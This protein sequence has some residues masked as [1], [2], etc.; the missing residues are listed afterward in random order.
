MA[1][2]FLTA[3]IS[4]LQATLKEGQALLISRRSDIFYFSSF[5]A[6]VPEERSAFLLIT[7]KEAHLLLQNFLP[8]PANF[9]GLI[10][11]GFTSPMRLAE[12]VTELVKQNKLNSL[13]VDY[14]DLRV[15]ELQALQKNS[16]LAIRDLDRQ[17]VWQLR[18]QKDES[19]IAKIKKARS[20][21]KQVLL[22]TLAE[23][24]TGQSELEVARSIEKKIRAHTGCDL[25]FP[26]IVAFN[27][28]SALP[29]HQPGSKRL[30]HGSVVLIDVGATY[31][32]YCADMTRTIFW[33]QNGKIDT[34]KIKQ[35]T[36]QFKKIERLVKA[37]YKKAEQLLVN[38]VQLTAAELDLA[39]RDFLTKA[40]Y[41]SQFIHTTGHG[42]GLDIHEPPSLY[43]NNPQ[44]LLPGMV[45]TIEPGIYLPGKFGVR[46]E[47]TVVVK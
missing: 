12:Y 20:I 44:T 46:W 31:Q 38:N 37:A 17:V 25:A 2:R 21:T 6:N 34:P 22:H 9:P 39:C 33:R 26:S 28:H 32:H 14:N 24:R 19:E 1:Q 16:N 13:K 30:R 41:G 8:E 43:L 29:H 3:R 5:V 10:S 11:Q 7:A 47:N 42:L 27:E 36:K 40:G 18:S 35:K 45:I 4:K 23:L 15:A